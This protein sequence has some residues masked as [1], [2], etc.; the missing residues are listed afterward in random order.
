MA[1]RR[2]EGAQRLGHLAR[3]ALF[4]HRGPGR[5]G[6]VFLRVARR[7]D[8]LPGGAQEAFRLRRRAPRLSRRRR[9]RSSE[10]IARADVEQYH[11]IGKD[12]VYFHTLFWPAMLR[13]SERKTPTNVFVH[14]FLNMALRREDVEVARH[15]H[16]PA[17]LPRAR[18]EP[19]VAAL[20]HRGQAQRPGRG[21][22]VQ[23]GRFRRAREQRPRRQVRQHREPRGAVPARNIRRKRCARPATTSRQWWLAATDETRPPRSA[24]RSTTASTAGR[25][26]GDG[27]CRPDQPLLRREAKP[28]AL[29]KDP[30]Q[31]RR[32][33]PRLSSALH[34]GL[35]DTCRCFLAPI[36]PA[37]TRAARELPRASTA[38][39]SWTRP[40]HVRPTRIGEYKH[41][42]TRIDPK[43]VDALLEPPAP[44]PQP[45]PA[46]ARE[47]ATATAQGSRQ[48]GFDHLHRRLRQGRLAHRAH[49]QRRARRRRRQA[50]EAHARHRRRP[51][52]APCSPASS[53]PTIP[54]SS[55]AA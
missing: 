52:R 24:T 14:G 9:A 45:S 3:R 19:G 36:L 42:M 50:P 40:A 4:R 18:H 55:S 35:Q 23:P 5:A 20:L 26:Q 8:R 1:R 39:S 49:R 16:Q 21:P 15:R 12:I 2:R 46:A 6:Q 48:R 13:F 22:R 10:F 38:T 29:A 17:A 31:A 43:L 28:W 34:R 25:A 27:A 53:P 30:A 33:A 32:A 44:S 7:P 41:L 37:T 47:G 51:P 11:F 54:R